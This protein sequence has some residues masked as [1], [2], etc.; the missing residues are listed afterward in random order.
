[1]SAASWLSPPVLDLASP[2]C[3]SA[4]AERS[5]SEETDLPNVRRAI[6]V[7]IALATL[8][9][10]AVPASAAVGILVINSQCISFGEGRSV[11]ISNDTDE[12]VLVYSSADCSGDEIGDVY[13]QSGGSFFAG[14]VFIT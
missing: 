5:I 10:L 13:P 14:S 2:H 3:Y 4:H 12:V 1:V 6:A 9:P 11:D 8:L 7:A